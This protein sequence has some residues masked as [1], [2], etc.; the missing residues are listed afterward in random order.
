MCT[1]QH[2]DDVD[3]I[4][5]CRISESVELVANIDIAL[6]IETYRMSESVEV[7][8]NVETARPQYA[9]DDAFMSAGPEYTRPVHQLR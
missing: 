2:D 9:V 5:C 7:F 3:A 1:D 6:T 4:Q 8:T